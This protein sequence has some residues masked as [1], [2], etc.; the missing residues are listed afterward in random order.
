MTRHSKNCTN[1]AVYSYHER[2][3]DTK[4]SGYGLQRERLN[5]DAVK[6]YNACNL[7]LQACRM[8]DIT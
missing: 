3:R 6:N 1:S 8:P 7:T 4:N 2:Q 5:K